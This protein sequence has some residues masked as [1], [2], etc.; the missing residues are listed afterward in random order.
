MG[1]NAKI[2]LRVDDKDNVATVFANGVK[3]GDAI[4]VR[5]KRGG[6][7]TITACSDIPFGHKIAVSDIGQG[8]LIMKY[9]ERIGIA[10]VD[11]S[12]GD[13]VHIHNLEAVRG[14]GDLKGE[15]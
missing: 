13:Y 6:S 10:S 7:E 2:A 5:D 11:I 14:R 8:R 9:G 4:E 1:I 15:N 12:R 3:Q